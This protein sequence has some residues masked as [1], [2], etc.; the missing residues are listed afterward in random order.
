MLTKAEFRL[1]GF[2]A[3][4]PVES[5]FVTPVFLYNHEYYLQFIDEENVIAG[6]ENLSKEIDVIP[7]DQFEIKVRP[8]DQ[9]IFGYLDGGQ[10]FFARDAEMAIHLGGLLKDVEIESER[11]CIASFIS[12]Y[13][14]PRIEPLPIPEISVGDS[15]KTAIAIVD[16]HTLIR[17]GFAR[18][19]SNFEQYD[20]VLEASDGMEFI[21][22][23]NTTRSPDIVLLDINMP[24]LNAFETASWIRKNSPEMKM[25]ASSKV[26]SEG[27]MI[28]MLRNGAKG[29]ILKDI[30]NNE[31]K[32][33]LNSVVGDGYYYGNANKPG[34]AI[35]DTH[36]LMRNAIAY[37]IRSFGKFDVLFEV[38]DGKEL[39]HQ[40][41]SSRRPDV[42][43]LD[44]SLP[45]MD[46]FETAAYLKL[47]YPSIKV[48][49]WSMSNTDSSII[50]MLRNGARGYIMK[51]IE[52]A[53]LEAAIDSVIDK[54]YY[55]SEFVTARLMSNIS[56][57]EESE[58]RFR[59]RMVLNEREL[60]FMKLV[61]TEWTYKEIA[62]RMYLSPRT[63][64]GYRD[65]LFEKLNVKTRV[66]LVLYALKNGIV[67]VE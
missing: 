13:Y 28:R 6:F 5:G 53:E 17:D 52:P 49:A 33:A 21:E 55:H 45:G 38:S 41:K 30:D 25:I 48:L 7:A 47:H 42:V 65:A 34:V 58:S 36:S 46:G 9:G 35:V 22:K 37:L 16:D 18:R 64:D 2:H 8:G 62:N 63:I 11:E 67:K 60:E 61:C 19:I 10:I 31:L 50:R 44:T 15:R 3:I 27:S 40:L 1:I 54:G 12:K 59:D 14:K 43:L 26:Y 56:Q 20:V 39:I 24:R 57:M 29:Y 66:G 23:L 51:D 4:L 32:F